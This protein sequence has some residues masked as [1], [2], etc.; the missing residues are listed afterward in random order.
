[1][2]P[3]KAGKKQDSFVEE[4]NP[5]SDI[6]SN[7]TAQLTN[8]IKS[9]KH[10]Y[11]ILEHENYLY[12]DDSGREEDES[13]ASK[14][15]RVAKLELHKVAARPKLMPYTDMISWALEHV[16]IPTRTI[17]SHQKTIIGPFRPEDIQVMYKLTPTPNILTMHHL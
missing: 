17:Y 16:D 9:W 7:T 11:E 2:A 12:Y 13:F 1:M 5:N 14:L 3:R 6:L 15:S 4:L 10:V 8:V